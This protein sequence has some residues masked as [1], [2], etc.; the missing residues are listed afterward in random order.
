MKNFGDCTY[1]EKEKIVIWIRL[2]RAFAPGCSR[3]NLSTAVEEVFEV[4]MRTSSVGAWLKQKVVKWK[5]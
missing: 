1:D 4:K 3:K 2:A 5:G